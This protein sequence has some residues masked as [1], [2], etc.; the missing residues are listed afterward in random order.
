MCGFF[1]SVAETRGHWIRT[2]DGFINCFA[3]DHRFN[4][5]KNPIQLST[6]VASHR[7]FQPSRENISMPSLNTAFVAALARVSPIRVLLALNY[8]CGSAGVSICLPQTIA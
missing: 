7:N 4:T 2:V 6:G 1:I 3:R 8:R 5:F